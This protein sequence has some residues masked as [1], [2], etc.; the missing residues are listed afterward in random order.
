MPGGRLEG[1]YTGEASERGFVAASAGVGPGDVYLRGGDRPD[2]GLVEQLGGDG[3]DQ[4]GD[5][6]FQF[7]YLGG[8]SSDP[9]GYRTHGLFG[10]GEFVDG[11]RW[12][13][14]R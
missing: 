12:E 13:S 5:G 2:S 6:C 7:G 10:G 14:K 9:S 3:C 8:E 11:C 4:F 1:C